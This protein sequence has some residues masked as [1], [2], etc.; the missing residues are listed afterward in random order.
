MHDEIHIEY[1]DTSGVLNPLTLKYK[2]NDT[3]IAKK[4]ANK[5]HHCIHHFE[6][7]EPTRFYGFDDY[8][9]EKQKAIT[10]INK[11]VDTI[12]DY[13]PGFVNRRLTD[14]VEQDTLNYFHHIFEVYHGLLNKPH[15]FY[16][17]APKDVQ[18]ALA[19]INIEVHRC[20][21]FV[22]NTGRKS[23]P[24]HIVTWFDMPRNDLLVDEDY[25]HFTDQFEAGTI[26][27]QYV[28]IGKTLEDLATDDDQ[29]I[30]DEAFKPFRHYTADFL[31]RFFSTSVET[32]KSNRLK[33]L[34][35]YKKNKQFFDNRG[36]PIN[37]IYN[38]PGNIPVA[39]IM[40]TPIDVLQEL[41]HRQFVSKISLQ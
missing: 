36:L 17:D 18:K 11:C 12:N 5:V 38:R 14:K 34:D 27:I 20:E 29:H 41:K 33:M 26:Y 35:Y 3:N 30:G 4:W 1:S 16:I 13:S 15:Q 9:T 23:V 25:R 32:W 8:Q 6:I 40:P 21:S 7:D 19:Q 37:H 31:V 39:K 2:I 22:E 28:E 24:R 10:A